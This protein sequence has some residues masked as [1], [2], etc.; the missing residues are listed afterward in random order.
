MS[1]C[2]GCNKE[3]G[4]SDWERCTVIVRDPQPRDYFQVPTR[5]WLLEAGTTK[6]YMMGGA[7]FCQACYDKQAAP[8][9]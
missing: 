8:A 3:V 2:K 6:T 9:S 5:V 1:A 7:L 4:D